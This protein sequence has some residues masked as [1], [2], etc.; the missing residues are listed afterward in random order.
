MLIINSCSQI[1]SNFVRS[2][3]QQTVATMCLKAAGKKINYQWAVMSCTIKHSI[4]NNDVPVYKTMKKRMPQLSIATM[5][6]D[7]AWPT[8]G[9]HLSC[10]PFLFFKI[11]K[12]ISCGSGRTMANYKRA[13]AFSFPTDP[14]WK[15][16]D[17]LW[18]AA[19]A[20]F[21][22][23]SCFMETL[24]RGLCQP[25]YKRRGHLPPLHFLAL[26]F[27]LM[28]WWYIRSPKQKNA[29]VSQWQSLSMLQQCQ[30]TLAAIY[31]KM[32][33]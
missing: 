15:E 26:G 10:A 6:L 25:T 24:V 19:T 31:V 20:F 13:A 22:P 5:I 4:R 30:Y 32:C 9:S 8:G 7:L 21:P 3:S 14:K 18:P 1:K 17:E 12:S 29:L 27:R 16:K 11:S 28:V 33:R 23:L 2:V